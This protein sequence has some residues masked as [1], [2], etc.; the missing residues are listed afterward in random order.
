MYAVAALLLVA[1]A[2]TACSPDGSPVPDEPPVPD[3][4]STPG[5]VHPLD[6]DAPLVEQLAAL[7]RSIGDSRIVLLGENG[8][9]VG[10]ITEAKARL[11]GWLHEELGFEVVVFESGFFECG[12]AWERIDSLTP[13]DAL[14]DCLRYPFQHA[15]V[16]PV[17]ERVKGSA[18]TDRPLALAG[19][20]IQAQGFDSG[21]RPGF[22][23]RTLSGS[24]ARSAA[25]DS[26]FAA[27]VASLDSALYLVPDSGGL[28]D[29][30]YAWAAEH[31][32]SARALYA[33]AADR[34]DGWERWVFEL[35]RGWLDRLE[36]RGT[37][38][39]EGADALPVRYYELRDEWMARAVSALAD[40]IAG[41]RKVV[42]WLHNDHARY[43]DFEAG[44]GLSRSVGGHLREM[45][46]QRVYSI[47]VFMG[48]G[49]IAANGRE[50]RSTVP[51]PPG[52]IEEFLR[53]EAADGSDAPDAADP[54]A[55]STTS[56]SADASFLVLR[57]NGDPAA[58]AWAGAPRPYLR[59]GIERRELVPA[60]EF[61]ALFYV[62]TATVPTYRIR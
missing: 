33:R 49:E 7:E 27:R 58:A 62:D 42:V 44:S 51:A 19:M 4:P 36:V 52:G 22:S 47:G 3:R 56:G 57:G 48:G 17:F 21:A 38:E 13:A 24:D 1:T 60:E 14:Y 28:G 53:V 20:D 12:R 10:S 8:H 37:A 54:S 18:Y 23:F 31:G 59:M 2:S 43:G 50:V 9:G 6:L 16:L 29:R 11:V 45:H 39:L 55:V 35:A 30:L 40:S 41:P 5:G 32:D 34:T 46:G 15:E 26:T 25:P 61:D